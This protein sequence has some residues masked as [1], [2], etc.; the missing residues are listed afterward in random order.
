MI[1]RG[2]K[3]RYRSIKVYGLESKYLR[4]L[5]YLYIYIPASWSYLLGVINGGF[6]VVF[7]TPLGGV[8]EGIPIISNGNETY[9]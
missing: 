6:N 9:C 8:N 3:S 2:E 5:R 7:V 4:S 1:D